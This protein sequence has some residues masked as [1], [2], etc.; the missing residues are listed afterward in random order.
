MI[1]VASFSYNPI[2]EKLVDILVNKTQNYNRD[3]FRLQANFY[4]SLVAST[5]GIKV[6]SPITGTI[7]VNFYGV[8]LATSGSGKGFSTNLI[9]NQVLLNFREK[10]VH[11]VFPSKVKLSLDIE[12]LNRASVLGMSQQEA[13]EK[14]EKEFKSYGAYKFTFDSATSPAIKQFRHKLLL[15]KIGSINFIIDEIGANLKANLEPLYVF[16]ELFDKGLIKDKLTKSTQ[17]NVRFQELTG[18]TPANLL[19]FGTPSKLL[20]GGSIE[21]EFF[22]LCE[23]GYARRCF[24]AFSRKD[25]KLTDLTP[26]ELYDAMSNSHQESDITALANRLGNLAN[27][28]LCGATIQTDRDIGIK[29][30]EYRRQCELAANKMPEHQEILKSELSHRYFKVLKLAGAYAFLEGKLF[31]NED[32]LNQAIKFA[33]DSGKALVQLMN[34]EKPY[35]RLAKFIADGRGKQFTQ[36]DLV[37]EL[38]YYKGSITQKNEL[39]SMAVAW[40][41]TNNILIK[42]TVTD[43]IE[44][45]SGESLKET[46]LSKIK[47]A[48]SQFFGDGYINAEVSWDTAFDQLLPKAGYNWINHFSQDGKRNNE[49]MIP[50]FNVIVLD[51]DGGISLNQAQELLKDYE[52]IIHTTKRHQ[53]IDPNTGECNDRFRVILPTN[54]ELKLSEPEF[55]KFMENVQ[56]WCPFELDTQTFQRSRKWSCTENTDIYKNSGKLVDVLPFIPRTSRETEFNKF[57]ES[58]GSMDAVERWFAQQ[59]QNGNR[60]NQMLKFALLMLDNGESLMNIED[61]IIEFND[62]LAN[63]LDKAEIEQ[64]IFV[65]LR[66]KYEEK[67]GVA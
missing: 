30:L 67:Y 28:Q 31:I 6:N 14:L 61:K 66:K 26:E 20:D 24:F 53:V 23:M 11:D 8:N 52:Y 41:Y 33:E 18:S 63:P 9:E 17:D 59:M 51:V 43:N 44:F 40:G 48:Y 39:M 65:T 16:L 45:F 49:S 1:D 37:E 27:I 38:P 12:A 50:G 60:N 62:K 19:L 46:D 2:I 58:I 7:P 47:I 25:I 34:R 54:Y 32:H 4:I 35:E 29:L 42:K 10:F 15:A 13:Y 57:H 3:F 5:M 36:V 55:K 56:K 64:T 21:S 22:D